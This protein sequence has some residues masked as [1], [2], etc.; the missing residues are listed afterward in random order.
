MFRIVEDGF[1]MYMPKDD[2]D[3]LA[4]IINAEIP[5]EVRKHKIK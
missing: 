5:K 4:G 2:L 3:N 1:Y